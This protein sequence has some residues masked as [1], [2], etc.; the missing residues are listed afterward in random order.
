MLKEAEK[1]FGKNALEVQVLR[2]VLEEKRFLS[3]PKVMRALKKR[4]VEAKPYEVESA[5]SRLALAGFIEE[6]RF[7]FST[8]AYRA[9]K[10]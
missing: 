6:R 4:G 9:A 2:A 5:L 1:Y 7:A 3:L 8:Y 10:V